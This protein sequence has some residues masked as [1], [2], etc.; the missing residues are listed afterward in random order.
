VTDFP[1]TP[2]R[3]AREDAGLTQ[4]ALA[5]RAGVSQATVCRVEQGR[6]PELAT[7]LALAAALGSTVE[8]LF[9]RVG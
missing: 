9:P 2:L 6:P 3:R 7:A 1:E 8:D 5:A 4:D